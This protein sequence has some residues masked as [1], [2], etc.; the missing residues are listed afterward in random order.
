[1]ASRTETRRH[2]ETLDP[3]ILQ[4]LDGD[5]VD[6]PQVRLGRICPHPGA[7][8]HGGAGVGILSVAAIPASLLL[9]LWLA[10]VAVQLVEPRRPHGPA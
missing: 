3:Q 2:I 5:E 10:D 8:L 1:M 9:L 4:K 7:V 6:L